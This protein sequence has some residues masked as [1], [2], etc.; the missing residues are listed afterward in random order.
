MVVS[1]FLN[2]FSNDRIITENGINE[3]VD[4]DTAYSIVTSQPG[5]TFEGTMELF[6]VK[7]EYTLTEAR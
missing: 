1:T 6:W 2:P 4:A 3:P 5:L 7:V